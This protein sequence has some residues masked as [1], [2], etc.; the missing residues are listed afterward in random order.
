MLIA[1]ALELVPQIEFF[2][3]CSVVASK[4]MV[5]AQTCGL[6]V[7]LN[8]V[9]TTNDVVDALLDVGNLTLQ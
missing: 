2:D 7:H 8:I 5:V 9:A 3:A 1:D 6:L 4:E